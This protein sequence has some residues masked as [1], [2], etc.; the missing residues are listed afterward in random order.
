MAW[1]DLYSPWLSFW[2]PI[3]LCM[4]SPWRPARVSTKGLQRVETKRE[5]WNI[6]V[7]VHTQRVQRVWS[8]QSK[9]SPLYVTKMFGFVSWIWSNHLWS[10]AACNQIQGNTHYYTRETEQHCISKTR[11][12]DFSLRWIRFT[13]VQQHTSSSSLKTVKGPS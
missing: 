8:H 4:L 9:K 2:K 3:S 6:N 11:C 1:L 7:T 12:F 10:I 13:T 5:T